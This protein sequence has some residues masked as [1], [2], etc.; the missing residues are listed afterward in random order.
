MTARTLDI[1]GF[2]AAFERAPP[3]EGVEA[4]I[5]AGG[6][7]VDGHDRIGLFALEERPRLLEDAY[8]PSGELGALWLRIARARSTGAVRRGGWDTMHA[9]GWGRAWSDDAGPFV[10]IDHGGRTAWIEGERLLLRGRAPVDR[11]LVA[12]IEPYVSGDWMRRGVRLRLRDGTT[13]DV[14]HED[15]DTPGID[16]TYDGL[17]LMADTAWTHVLA[18]ALRHGLGPPIVD[19]T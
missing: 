3:G 15:D 19:C 11:S 17:N 1:D 9:T 2:V 7:G 12:A 5:A 18:Q 10:L 13:R 4:L 8:L 16:P 14:A 6:W